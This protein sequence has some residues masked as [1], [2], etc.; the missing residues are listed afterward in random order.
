MIN[1]SVFV[2]FVTCFLQT[3]FVFP[4][5]LSLQADF[6]TSSYLLILHQS[7]IAARPQSPGVGVN[8]VGHQKFTIGINAKFNFHVDQGTISGGPSALE[9]FENSQSHPLHNVQFVFANQNAIWCE[10]RWDNLLVRPLWVVIGIVLE[11]G[12]LKRWVEFE[13]LGNA[14]FARVILM[15]L[16]LSFTKF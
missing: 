11:E 3:K 1:K 16:I 13:S 5:S 12:L 7:L 9:N 15:K 4:Q 10:F 14:C 2:D 8:D 6:S